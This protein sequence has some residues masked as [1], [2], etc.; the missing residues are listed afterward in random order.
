MSDCLPSAKRTIKKIFLKSK[1]S[2]HG[3]HLGQNSLTKTKLTITISNNRNTVNYLELPKIAVI[4]FFER[5]EW[6]LKWVIFALP[7]C[8]SQVSS[9][10]YEYT[11]Q[12]LQ[13]T[14]YFLAL[15]NIRSDILPLH[16]DSD[17]ESG[18]NLQHFLDGF[19]MQPKFCWCCVLACWLMHAPW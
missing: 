1:S 2:L 14:S 7:D 9:S 13:L 3:F 10:A 5:G 17:L 11:I 18:C 6:G 4:L 12:A 15:E 16:V 19:K 8:V